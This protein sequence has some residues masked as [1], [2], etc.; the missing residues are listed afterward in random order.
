MALFRTEL[1]EIKEKEYNR[2]FNSCIESF[3]IVITSILS[4]IELLEE[5]SDL[6]HKQWTYW[7]QNLSKNHDLPYWLVQHWLPNQR[8]YKFLRD[9][10]KEDDRKW[11]RKAIEIIKKKFEGLIDETNKSANLH[12]LQT[13]DAS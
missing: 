4:D 7:T 8:E 9:D 5:L 13:T 2:G 10:I 6:E 12:R 1:D 3:K 11:A